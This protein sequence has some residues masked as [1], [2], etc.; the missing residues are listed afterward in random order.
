MLLEAVSSVYQ[1]NVDDQ[2]MCK[3]GK[4]VFQAWEDNRKMSIRA[5]EDAFI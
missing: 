5:R 4:N 3:V 2:W 1:R